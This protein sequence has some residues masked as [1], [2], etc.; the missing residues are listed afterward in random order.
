MNLVIEIAAYLCECVTILLC[1]HSFLGKKFRLDYKTIALIIVEVITM[2]ALFELELPGFFTFVAQIFFYIYVW[3][4]FKLKWQHNIILTMLDMM[5]IVAVQ[6]I[7]TLPICIILEHVKNDRIIALVINIISLFVV[8]LLSQWLKLHNLYMKFVT[9]DK[10]L[11]RLLLLCGIIFVDLLIKYKINENMVVF[12]Y[13][14]SAIMVCILIGSIFSW[15]K[16]RYEVKQKSLELHMHEL[17]GKTFEDMIEN[18]RIRQHDFKNQLAAIYGMHLTAENFEELVERQK[19]YCDYLIEESRF[20]KILTKCKDKVLAGFLYTKFTEVEKIG[21]DIEFD[22]SLNKADCSLATYELIELIGILIDNAVEYEIENKKGKVIYFKLSDNNEN[23]N[24]IC[25]NKADYI[26]IET[27]NRFFQKGYSTKGENRG[28]GLYNVKKMLENRG[29]IIVENKSI[30]G[31]NW[32]EFNII[33]N[34]SS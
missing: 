32:L 25:R 13:F 3:C 8:V 18:I 6:S 34:R 30:D 23:L 15:Q 22:I 2:T 20:D 16:D 14:I 24:I 4:K 10:F 19:K 5:A 17:Y 31:E 33:I 7:V 9:W 28:I 11:I 12:A 1:I 21:A 26:P 29:Q 27:I